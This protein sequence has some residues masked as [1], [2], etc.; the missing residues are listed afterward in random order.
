MLTLA[1]SRGRIWDEAAPLLRALKL[2]PDAA[3][4]KTRQL[5]IPT[6]NPNV[7]LLQVRA[8]D[9]PAFVA[10]GAAQAGIAG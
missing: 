7:R 2:A 1:V 3:A 10:C 5:I 6:E 9:A 4:L 8:Q